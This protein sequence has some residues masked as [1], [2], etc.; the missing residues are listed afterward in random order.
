MPAAYA[1]YRFGQE[2]LAL[3]PEAEKAVAERYR[4]LFEIGLHGP[5]ILFYYRP[6]SRNAV[7]RTGTLAHA[8]PGRVYFSQMWDVVQQQENPEPYLAYLYGFLCHFT[9]D[10][11]CHGYINETGRTSPYSHSEL[12]TELDRYFLIADGR[13]PMRYKPTGHLHPTGENAAVIA[14]FFPR[15]TPQEIRESL[16]TMILVENL[17]VAS[18]PVKRGLVLA[19]V[20]AVGM[21]DYARG[22]M[23]P[24]EAPGACVGLLPPIVEMYGRAVPRAARFISSFAEMAQ[25]IL[26]FDPCFALPFDPQTA[27]EAPAD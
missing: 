27:A 10:S 19:A 16:S 25:G 2:V 23:R 24:Y 6:L 18:N 17:W 3:L 12:E 20:R 14:A 7:N 4:S 5:D 1:H 22:L 9:L 26:P 13:N 11:A 15:I 21:Y 8:I